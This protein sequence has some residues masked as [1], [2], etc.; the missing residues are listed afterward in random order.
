MKKLIFIIS[1]VLS[2]IIFISCSNKATIKNDLEK[3]GTLGSV[4]RKEI[5]MYFNPKYVSK[6]WNVTDTVNNYTQIYNYDRNGFILNATYLM[7]NYFYKQ[8]FNY[9]NNIKISSKI[10]NKYDE[11]SN[12]NNSVFEY[13]KNIIIET[14]YTFSGCKES[15][16]ISKRNENTNTTSSETKMYDCEGASELINHYSRNEYFFNGYLKKIEETNYLTNKKEI[17]EL[18]IIEKD[19][20]GNPI[21]LISTLNK[22]PY[23]LSIIKYDYY[24]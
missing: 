12:N 18:E 6:K 19:A 13:K 15:V 16:T 14:T 9:K 5:K 4:K 8:T 3:T 7:K 23:A 17:Q 11:F 22:K 24:K 21:K 2:L 1:S 20:I 10:Y